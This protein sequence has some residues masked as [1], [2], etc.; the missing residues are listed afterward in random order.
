[1]KF[2]FEGDAIALY[3]P[4]G[5][6]GA[7]YEVAINIGNALPN[8]YTTNK[9]FFRPNMMLYQATG[10]GSGSHEV[11]VKVLPGNDSSGESNIFAIDYAQVFTAPSL[12]GK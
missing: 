12:G 2:T 11:T 8:N 9:P 6:K 1:M 7:A 3:G 4:V 5:P 10:L